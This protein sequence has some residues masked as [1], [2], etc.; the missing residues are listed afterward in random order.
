MGPMI[1][2]ALIRIKDQCDPTLSFRRSCR[3]GICGSCAMNIYGYNCLA[4]ITKVKITGSTCSIFPLPHMYVIKDL[5]VDMNHFFEQYRKIQ[6]YLMRGKKGKERTHQYIQSIP[7]SEKMVGMYE[8]IL[9]ACCSTSCPSYW[10]NGDKYLGPAALMHAYRWII[11]G[12]DDHHMERLSKI[13]D[14]YSAFRCN[15][16]MNCTVACPK[17]LNPGLY[18]ARLKQLI[19]GLKKK[20]PPQM[21]PLKLHGK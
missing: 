20:P 16:I 21:D 13:N 15:T 9:C 17:Q 2:D 6:P 1:L 18:I 3:E 5:V 10:W 14:N 11:D 19:T 12:R 4:C 8:C 7:D